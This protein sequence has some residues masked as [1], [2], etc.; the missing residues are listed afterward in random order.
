MKKWLIF[1]ATCLL[2]L[3]LSGCTQVASTPEETV[4]VQRGDIAVTVEVNGNLEMPRKADLSFG[5]GGTVEEV[6]VREGDRVAKGQVLA[7][8]DARSLELNLAVAQA[9]YNTAQINLMKTIYPHYTKTWGVD[10]PGVWLA[11]EEAENNLKQAQDLL[12]EGKIGE[13]QV[14]LSSVGESLD[15]AERKSLFLP[16]QLPWSVKL[17]ELQVD[18]AQANLDAARINLEK[19]SIVAPFDG[20]VT[21]VNITPGKEVTSMTLSN[22]AISMVDTS[23]ILMRGFVDEMDIASVE[24]GQEATIVL[25]ALPS[26]EVK[27]KVTFISPVGKVQAGVVVY[28]TTITLDNPDNELRDGMSATAEIVVERRD[29]VLLIPNK[30]IRGGLEKPMVLVLRN[31][32]P[33]EQAVV[34]GLSDGVNTEVLSGLQE[35]EQVVLPAP[36]TR[37]QGYFM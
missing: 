3:T 9:Q 29:N 31:G 2:V 19:A 17:L 12:K 36:P 10:L 30:A 28:D 21:Q 32:H 5:V 23:E 4:T 7:R 6:L 37:P 1:I 14:L 35:G 24:V 20:I 15:K 33:Q 34:L 18:M 26:K 25:D 16:W 13:A 22:P 11:L 27:G 8:L